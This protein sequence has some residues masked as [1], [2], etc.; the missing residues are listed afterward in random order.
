[1]PGDDVAYPLLTYPCVG[2]LVRHADGE[3]HVGEV[4]EM[5]I[6]VLEV[7]PAAWRRVVDA[8]VDERERRLNDR[9]TEDDAEH[10]TASA[11][12][13]TASAPLLFDAS[14][15]VKKIAT[16]LT[17]L[18]PRIR[19]SLAARESSSAI[20]TRSV[21]FASF[22]MM[23]AQTQPRKTSVTVSQPTRTE[24]D[25]DARRANQQGNCEGDDPRAGSNEDTTPGE[26]LNVLRLPHTQHL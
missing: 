19:P 14:A 9:P 8:R 1:V 21:P 2:D 13:S 4:P 5:G 26:A 6:P 18:A 20:A 24:T 7:D 11:A 12:S 17:T 23:V 25:Q 16:R 3:R 22:S 10:G 15:R